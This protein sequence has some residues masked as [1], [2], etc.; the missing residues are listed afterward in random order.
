ML[1]TI[2]LPQTI[3]VQTGFII[4]FR[5]HTT[6]LARTEARAKFLG[7]GEST[8]LLAIKHVV[9]TE[10]IF[11][12]LLY[13]RIVHIFTHFGLTCWPIRV[14]ADFIQF[15]KRIP[16]VRKGTPVRFQASG[17]GWSCLGLRIYEISKIIA[18]KKT[19][20]LSSTQVLAPYPTI[21]Q[22]ELL[23]RLVQA[24][25]QVPLPTATSP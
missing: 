22:S 2:C 21:I 3:R 6:G 24:Y 25:I 13:K 20:I 19:I 16:K 18:S 9:V 1:L 4:S 10:L 14:H 7:W 15:V 11:T 5:S 17:G 23:H 12:A 8:L